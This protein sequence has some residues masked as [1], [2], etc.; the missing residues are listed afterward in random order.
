MFTPS[1]QARKLLP[2]ACLLCGALAASTAVDADSVIVHGPHYVYRLTLNDSPDLC[3]HMNQVFNEG[4][5]T[6]WDTSMLNEEDPSFAAD[7]EFAFPRLPGVEHDYKAT[8]TM[9]SSKKPSSPE[10]DAVPW[11]E[12]RAILG[13]PP[14][15]AGPVNDTPMPILVTYVDFYNDGH[16]DAVIK[17]Q[18]TRGY[19]YMANSGG[20]G[21]DDELITVILDQKLSPGP[22]L[23]WWDLRKKAQS[24][25]KFI[26]TIDAAYERLFIYKGQTYVA[27]YDIQLSTNPNAVKPSKELMS[28]LRYHV[29]DGQGEV[30]CQY[31][32][33]QQPR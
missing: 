27:H 24:S 17:K 1:F 8:F 12:G 13:D 28:V 30:I 10:F 9:L 22:T 4:F 2:L 3:T 15:S 19:S 5:A 32:M 14:E 18:F 23:S 20:N 6:M 25:S 16:M 31:R 11:K 7:S 26:N 29:S 33:I 21:L